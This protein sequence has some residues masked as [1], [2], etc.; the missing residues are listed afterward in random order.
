MLRELQQE[1][2]LE[3]KA[4]PQRL[5]MQPPQ[6]PAMYTHFSQLSAKLRKL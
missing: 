3:P 4:V 5:A 1:Q 2:E 6:E